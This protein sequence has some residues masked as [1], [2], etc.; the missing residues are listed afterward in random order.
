MSLFLRITA[1]LAILVLGGALPAGADTYK[2]LIGYTGLAAELGSATPTGAGVMVT[3]AEATSPGSNDY[4]PDIN[5][6]EFSGKTITPKTIPY[7]IS[8]HA[9]GVGQYFYGNSTSI[10]PGITQIDVYDAND[11]LGSGFLVTS[12]GFLP[13]ASS[14]RVAN[15]SWVGDYSDPTI[16]SEVLRRLDW[17]IDRDEYIQVVAMDNGSTNY[18]LLGSSFNAIAVGRSDGNH[19]IGS[20]ALDSIYTNQRTRPDLVA[21]LD[22]TSDATPVVA[23]GAALLVQTGHEGGTTLSTDPLVKS[24]TN[25]NGDTIYNAERS[26]VVKAALMAGADRSSISG[27]SAQTANGLDKRYGAGRLNIYNSYH[28]IAA[29]EQNSLEDG[30]SGNIGRYGFDYDP[31]FGGLS[32][33]NKTGSYYFHIS[34]GTGTLTVSLVWNLKIDGGSEG[35]FDGTATLYDLDLYLYEINGAS[36]VELASS[37]SAVDNTENI[38]LTNLPGS[39]DY[40]LMVAMGD[41]QAD[42]LWDYGLAWDISEV[43]LPAAWLLFGSGLLA[44]GCFRAGRRRRQ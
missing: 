16:N 35:S 8:G 4:F 33:S 43:P 25:R 40:L 19:A 24:T 36:L 9:T 7:S 13:L 23:A 32:G 15:H 5:N 11:W 1:L 39:H 26:E 20:V 18:P 21:P 2:D 38:Y 12:T 28:I 17:V 31:Y 22:Y 10:A 29:G 6:S 44:L 34:S 14:S 41:G 27:Y 30:G 3:Q 37:T 42:F